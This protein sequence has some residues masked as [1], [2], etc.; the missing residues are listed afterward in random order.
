MKNF[1]SYSKHIL[2]SSFL[3]IILQFN[4]SANVDTVIVGPNN[5]FTFSPANFTMNLGDTVLW[6]WSSGSHTTTS[7][8][9]PAGATKLEQSDDFHI[10]LI[11]VHSC[12]YR[13]L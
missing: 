12:S 8:S 13:K 3:F 6:I 10:H 4:L 7:S 2:L 5:S 11:Y 1:T 9:I